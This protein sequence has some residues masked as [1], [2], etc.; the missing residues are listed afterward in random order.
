MRRLVALAVASVVLAACSGNGGRPLDVVKVLNA[1]PAE[2]SSAA[3][4]DV[5]ATTEAGGVESAAAGGSRAGAKTAVTGTGTG[6][7]PAAPGSKGLTAG[8]SA[9]AKGVRADKVI[10]GWEGLADTT[11]GA[12]HA[13]GVVAPSASEADQKAQIQ[14]M[15]DDIN[16]RGGIGGKRVEMV[17]HFVDVTQ[18]TAESRG[19]QTCE[20]FTT[21]HEIFALVLDANHNQA[22]SRCMAQRK[23]PVVDVS[24]TVLPVDQKDLNEHA[25]YLYLPLHVNLSRLAAYVDAVAQQGFLGKDAKVGLLRYDYPTHVRA[26]DQVIVPALARHGVRLTDDFAFTPVR[27]VSDLGAAGS[28]AA[29]AVLRF[30]AEGVN[31]V[32]FLPSGWVILTVFPPAAESQGFR[33][34]YGVDSWESPVYLRNN[35]PAAQLHGAV[36]IGWWPSQDLEAARAVEIQ[37]TLP[38]WGH[39]AAALKAAGYPEAFATY[40]TPFL[41]IKEAIA[42]GTGLTAAGLRAGADK[43]GDTPYST[44]NFATSF[45]PGRS[46]GASAW[47]NIAYDDGCTCFNYTSPVYRIP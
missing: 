34:L 18:G 10:L 36:G 40:C 33:P 28:Q 30:K 46:D 45:G 12:T 24:A 2:S 27:E 38:N 47:R 42:R 29:N 9:L 16:G 4:S 20:F 35:A 8:P 21:D 5:T 26:R 41:F 37:R 19:Q 14:A 32:L 11:S 7:G 6:T 13:V 1:A 17:F 31:R 25:P 3:S 23:T 39:C 44:A 22:L 43:L 15:V